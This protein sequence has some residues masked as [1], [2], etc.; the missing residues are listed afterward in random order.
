MTRL[1]DRG[2]DSSRG[3]STRSPSRP[4]SLILDPMRIAHL[5]DPHLLSLSGARALDF[6]NKRWIGG[7]NLLIK[8]GKNHRNE[9]F[10][11]MVDDLNDADVDHVLCTGDITNLSLE[12]EFRFAREHFDRLELGPEH[13]TVLP[14]NHDAYV[15]GGV[16]HFH[17]YFGAYC[18]GDDGWGQGDARWPIVRMRGRVALIGLST[19]LH[20]PWFTAYG[21]IG[22]D[23]LERLRAILSDDR[24]DGALRLVAIHHPPVGGHSTSRVRGLHDREAFADVLADAGADLVLHGHEHRDLAGELAGPGAE[25]IPVRGIPSGTYDDGKRPALTARYRV[26]EIAEASGSAQVVGAR[27]RV[28]QP[29][30]GRFRDEPGAPEGE[31][32]SAAA[33]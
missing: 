27:V 10:E 6:A 21:R 2:K 18:R 31:R 20:T 26:Y 3:A 5:S 33:P 12:P 17:R 1:G 8:R 25:G 23:Q 4:R 14:G 16:E 22:D 30:E 28:W 32:T 29:S 24:L 7:M 11:A 13:V 19:S 9:I 15:Q